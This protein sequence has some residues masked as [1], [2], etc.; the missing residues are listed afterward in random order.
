MISKDYELSISKEDS[1]V[2]TNTRDQIINAH[3]DGAEVSN[4]S[5]MGHNQHEYCDSLEVFC[6]ERTNLTNKALEEVNLVRELFA[7]FTI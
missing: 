5:S 1:S 2:E 4:I 6:Q 3:K 7:L